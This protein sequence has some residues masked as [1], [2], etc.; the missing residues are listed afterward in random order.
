MEQVIGYFCHESTYFRGVCVVILEEKTHY[1]V[2]FYFNPILLTVS[3]KKIGYMKMKF[4]AKR[5][6]I[7]FYTNAICGSDP[8]LI[9]RYIILDDNI[10]SL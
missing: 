10:F 7:E 1:I 2:I 3:Y 5:S 6:R 8:G 4:F 9:E